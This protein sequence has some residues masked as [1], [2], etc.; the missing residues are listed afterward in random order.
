MINKMSEL[1]KLCTNITE[2]LSQ[3]DIKEMNDE[4]IVVFMPSSGNGVC[5]D[6][7]MLL[8]FWEGGQGNAWVWGECKGSEIDIEAHPEKVCRKFYKLPA[9]E[10]FL[11]EEVVK[12]FKERKNVVIW[13]IDNY[14]DKVTLGRNMHF[15]G[16]LNR[17]NQEIFGLCPEGET[18][19]KPVYVQPRNLEREKKDFFYA[20]SQNNLDEVKSIVEAGMDVNIDDGKALFK[21]VEKGHVDMVKY[22]LSV[23]ANTQQQYELGYLELPSDV[24]TP[25]IIE[26]IKERNIKLL[27]FKDGENTIINYNVSDAWKIMLELSVYANFEDADAFDVMEEN[28]IVDVVILYN[29]LDI[30]PVLF[31]HDLDLTMDDNILEKAIASGNVDIVKFLLEEEFNPSSPENLPIITAILNNNLEMVKMLIEYGVELNDDIMNMALANENEDII[32][33]IS[34]EM[35]VRR[36]SAQ[37]N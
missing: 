21:A 4:D 20:V 27:I 26:K 9:L 8:Q 35:A 22:L 18:C 6:K 33:T 25:E 3:E 32:D 10:M 31:E 1:K 29:R 5:L 24:L 30:L 16:E 15:V 13:K 23:G 28:S 37:A 7:D 12:M 14:G 36:R 2:P 19:S 17:T 34:Y 11:Y